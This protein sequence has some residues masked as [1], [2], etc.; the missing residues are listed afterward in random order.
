VF[1]WTI[2]ERPWSVWFG[3]LALWVTVAL[4]AIS[5]W[6]YLWRNRQIY[7]SDA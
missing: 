1:G 3:Q 7:L 2:A 4:T 5:G 6:L